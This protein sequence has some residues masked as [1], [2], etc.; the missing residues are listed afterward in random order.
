MCLLL[1][2]SLGHRRQE[3]GVNRFFDVVARR[4]F[5]D[6]SKTGKG[7]EEMRCSPVD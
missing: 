5:E 1:S 6:M 7:R 4:T 2:K 3:D